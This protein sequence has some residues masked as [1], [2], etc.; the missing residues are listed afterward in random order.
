MKN[1]PMSIIAT[2]IMLWIHV[3]VAAGIYQWALWSDG[4]T[5]AVFVLFIIRNI[6]I[7]LAILFSLS[8]IGYKGE[9]K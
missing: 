9:K 6:W 7:G 2:M 8:L 1:K 4:S 5:E 3:A